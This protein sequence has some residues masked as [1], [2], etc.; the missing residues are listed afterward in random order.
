[1][2]TIQQLKYLAILTAVDLAAFG[3]GLNVVP[4]LPEPASTASGSKE[5]GEDEFWFSSWNTPAVHP[6]KGFNLRSTLDYKAFYTDNP[7]ASARARSDDF[8]HY[9]SPLIAVS[10]DFETEQRTTLVSVS[11][12]PTFVLS[13]LGNGGNRT[14]QLVRGDLT[15]LW[16]EKTVYLSH[17]YHQSS[18]SSTQSA[19]LTP[20]ESNQTS[21]GFRTPLSGKMNADFGLEQN[22]I[23]SE[24]AKS[25][26]TQ[27]LKSL[28]ANAHVDYQLRAKLQTGVRFSLG[29]SEQTGGSINT[30]CIERGCIDRRH[31]STA[32]GRDEVF[33]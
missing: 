30:K 32:A 3:A 25:N 28:V 29:Y 8:M 12:Q 22:L 16:N 13:S 10:R 2:R 15:H 20:Q 26:A 21:A 4:A 1:M 17:Q 19:F 31:A 33:W 9:V 23:N 5:A 27:E 14:Y 18:E 7:L 24:V 11:Y 6:W